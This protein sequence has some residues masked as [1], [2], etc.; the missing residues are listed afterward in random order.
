MDN[1]GTKPDSPFDSIHESLCQEKLNFAREIRNI[2][3]LVSESTEIFQELNL[4][5][6]IL[7]IFIDNIK[8][9]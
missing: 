7:S 1:T 3:S 6:P 4:G 5:R 2:N 9:S 8:S